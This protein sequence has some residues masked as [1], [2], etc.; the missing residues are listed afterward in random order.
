MAFVEYEENH[1]DYS[2]TC[3]VVGTAGAPISGRGLSEMAAKEEASK[4]RRWWWGQ[5]ATQYNNM[6]DGT[7]RLLLG[8]VI[9]LEIKDSAACLD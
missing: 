3:W 8:W 6:E 4:R 2:S 5:K 9:S 1:L 7:V